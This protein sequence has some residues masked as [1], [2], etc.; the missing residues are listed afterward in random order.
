MFRSKG[1]GLAARL[2]AEKLL[3]ETPAW[4]ERWK[5]LQAILAL[6]VRD[7]RH[8]EEILYQLGEYGESP[9]KTAADTLK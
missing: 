7:L 8:H 3:E 4:R 1:P 9:G 5:T 6:I 2:L